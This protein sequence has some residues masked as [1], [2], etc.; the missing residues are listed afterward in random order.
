MKLILTFLLIFVT[1]LCFCQTQTELNKNAAESYKIADKELNEVFMSILSDYKLDTV[2]TKNLIESE[3]I[4]IKFRDAE[5]KVKYPKREQ[6]YYGTIHPVCVAM[7]LEKLT[8]D[9]INTLKIWIEG[10]PEG[11]NCR[12]TVKDS[13]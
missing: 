13:R 4:W 7:Y 3:K 6:G 9:R 12:G 8:R 5:V 1:R 10:L 11:D 2:F